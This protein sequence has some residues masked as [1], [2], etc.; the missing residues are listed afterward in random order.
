[1]GGIRISE[2]S[3]RFHEA[4]KNYCCQWGGRLRYL[5]RSEP[6]AREL[7]GKELEAWKAWISAKGTPSGG[8]N[9]TPLPNPLKSSPR[10]SGSDGGMGAVTTKEAA[11]RLLEFVGTEVGASAQ[12][13]CRLKLSAFLSAFGNRQ[14]EKLS[15]SELEAWRDSIV[16][17]YNNPNTANERLGVARRLLTFANN[18]RL[19]TEQFRLSCLSNTKKKRPPRKAKSAEYVAEIINKVAALNPNLARH[20]LLAWYCCLRP[21]E[22]SRLVA[23]EG[24]YIPT[25]KDWKGKIFVPTVSKCQHKGQDRH[26]LLT[27]EALELLEQIR[28]YGKQGSTRQCLPPNMYALGQACRKLKKDGLDFSPHFIRHSSLTALVVNDTPRDCVETAAGHSM[29]Y[30]QGTYYPPPFGRTLEAMAILPKL[31]PYNSITFAERTVTRGEDK[32]PRKSR[33]KELQTA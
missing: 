23:G 14:L 31:I 28:E 19:V 33:N 4:S 13:F 20:L 12:K 17:R 30:V 25:N 15:E 10:G 22:I 18:R 2:P 5:G 27:I 16:K 3:F 24:E 7:F 26:I 6:Q 29:P 9:S 21:S 1:M 8:E 11:R 32:Q